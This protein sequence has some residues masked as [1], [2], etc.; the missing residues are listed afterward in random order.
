MLCKDQG[1]EVQKMRTNAK[2]LVIELCVFK[3]QTDALGGRSWTSRGRGTR[4]E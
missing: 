3:G 1:N 4:M 2:A